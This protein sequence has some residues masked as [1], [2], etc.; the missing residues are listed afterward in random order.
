M[1]YSRAVVYVQKDRERVILAEVP[2]SYQGGYG[3]YAYLCG[4][5]GEAGILGERGEADRG[6]GMAPT[7]A[8]EPGYN[9]RKGL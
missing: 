6:G 2:Y 1:D 4:S 9:F 8:A 3:I 7:R 5:S